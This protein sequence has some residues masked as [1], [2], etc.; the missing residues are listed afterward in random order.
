MNVMRSVFFVSD[1]TGITVEALG[2]SLLAQFPNVAF[3]TRV[4]PFVDDPEKAALVV[5]QINAVASG[6]GPRPLVF[7]TLTDPALCEII[8]AADCLCLDVMTGWLGQLE[9][10]LD[11][12]AK[13]ASGKTHGV[14]DTQT[15]N[16]RMDAVNFALTT[17]DGASTQ[18]YADA[19]IILVGL[20]RSGKTP[21]S[22]YLAMQHSLLVANY[23]LTEKDLEDLCLPMI[24]EQ[25]R[26]QL[27][28][29]TIEPARLYEIRS[30]RHPDSR[31]AS[32][33]QCQ[34]EVRQVEALYR[35]HSITPLN[36]TQLSV[37]EIASTI[38]RDT[39]L[40]WRDW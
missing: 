22:L 33:K 11:Q 4:L 29:L 26:Q 13:P 34:Y 14:V 35:Q 9:Q 10:A 20:S 37:E 3:D 16:R 5:Q 30:R 18:N 23:P 15:Y 32:L 36:T 7:A 17:D 1:H 21:T 6:G 39:E 38:L 8:A 27:Y 2:H 19:D 24:L 40:K 28:A 25:H 31:Y 12:P